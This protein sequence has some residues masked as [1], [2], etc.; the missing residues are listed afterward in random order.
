MRRRA[1]QIFLLLGIIGLFLTA[2]T[3]PTVETPITATATTGA[4]ET[5]AIVLGDISDDP[6]EVIDMTK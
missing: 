1:F 2:C 6:G 4:E 5:R 3:N